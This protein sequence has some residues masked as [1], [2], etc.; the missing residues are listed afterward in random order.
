MPAN[1]TEILPPLLHVTPENH[2]AWV[3]TVSTILLIVAALAT[4]VTLVSRVRILRSLTWSDT[5]LIAA[6]VSIPSMFLTGILT[7][8][9][10]LL[11]VSQTTCVNLASSSGIGKHRDTLSDVA[12]QSYNR[13]LYASQI[14]SVL[15]LACSKVAVALLLISIKPFNTVLLA[16]KI[17]LWLVGAWT[18]AF[19][20]ALAIQYAQL[21][22]WNLNFGRRIDQEALYTGL[23]VSHILLDIGLVVLPMILMRKVQM[24]KWKCFQICALFG[25]RVLVPVLT[26]PYIISLH[27]VFH[28]V[29]LDQ[30]WHIL[31]PT[32]WLQLVQSASIICTCI[33][34]LK[35]VFAEL[36]T[37][38]MAGTVS[39]FFELSVSGAQ[40]TMEASTS[41]S[42]K[43]NANAIGN[44]ELD[45]RGE[46]KGY[47]KGLRQSNHG[48]LI[49]PSVSMRNLRENAI[50]QSIQ[51]EAHWEP[52]ERSRSSSTSRG[53]LANHGDGSSSEQ[54]NRPA[55]K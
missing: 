44:S 36:Q 34:S 10:K 6:T 15:V 52:G 53:T 8:L 17:L 37:G 19:T 31:M 42:Q 29:A 3:I 9:C 33:P 48:R 16:C 35:R 30:T 25:L 55:F 7:M 22:V 47:L 27:P 5:F 4:I 32:L 12:F 23:A 54:F 43:Q 51:Y 24:S 11:F 49:E 39:E 20:I 50:V 38:M 26:I 46:R 40:G 45:S 2:G 28:S 18:F 13:F 21:Q 41:T 1:G 14:L